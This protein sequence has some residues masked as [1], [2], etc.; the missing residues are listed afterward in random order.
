[1]TNDLTVIYQRIGLLRNKGIRMK[2][3]ADL[4]GMPPSVVSALYATVLPAYFEAARS[5]TPEEALDYALSL[6]NNI[7]KKRLLSNLSHTREILEA[8]DPGSPQPAATNLFGKALAEGIR[9]S[10]G[11]IANY[12]GT[13]LSYSLSSSSDALKIEPYLICASEQGDYIKAG[14]LSAYQSI[15]W[16]CGIINNHQ[17]LYLSF[18]ETTPPELNLVTLYLQ[19]PFRDQPGMLRGLYLAL[20]YNRNPIA[21]RIVLVK[22]TTDTSVENFRNMQSGIIAR[23]QLSPEQEIYYQYTCQPGDYIKMGTVPSPQFDETDLIKEK[24]MLEL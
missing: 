20:D 12:A 1:M 23:E 3:I 8:F 2:E 19:L 7:S 18:S 4:T 22:T 21:R 24:K 13:Y 9:N 14:R 17:N 10:A 16:G 5:N 6:V 15:H 11:E